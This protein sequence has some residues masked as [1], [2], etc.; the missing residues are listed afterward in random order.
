MKM[1]LLF[2]EPHGVFPLIVILF[3]VGPR[4]VTFKK[5]KKANHLTVIRSELPIYIKPDLM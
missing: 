3:A 5:K 2:L 1:F 4:H